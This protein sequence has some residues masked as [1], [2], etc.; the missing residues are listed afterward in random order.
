MLF[1]YSIYLTTIPRS[2]SF[3]THI[4]LEILCKSHQLLSYLF[5][6][7]QSLFPDQLSSLSLCSF[8]LGLAYQIV[9]IIDYPFIGL[10]ESHEFL[11]DLILLIVALYLELVWM[12][13]QC[14]SAISLSKLEVRTILLEM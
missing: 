6:R 8:L 12:A 14:A 13:F 9:S 3:D 5:E 10:V 4:S 7:H 11:L 1:I 2:R